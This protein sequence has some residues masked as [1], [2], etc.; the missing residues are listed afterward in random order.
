MQTGYSVGHHVQLQTHPQ[1]KLD[2]VGSAILASPRKA[3]LHLLARRVRFQTSVLVEKGFDQVETPHSGCSLKIQGSPS[4]GEM[5]RCFAAT[6][7]QA[8]INESFTVYIG[9]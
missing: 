9:P 2:Y 3:A 1:Q 8:G 4:F 7:S 5:L 6:V